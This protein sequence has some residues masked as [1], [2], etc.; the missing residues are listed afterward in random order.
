VASDAMVVVN[1]LVPLF[2]IYC[3]FTMV[4]QTLARTVPSSP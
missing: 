3:R 1:L 4:S 2:T